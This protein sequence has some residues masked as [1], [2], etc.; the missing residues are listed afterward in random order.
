VNTKIFSTNPPE[1]N[2]VLGT[3][4]K[5]K[6]LIQSGERPIKFEVLPL[7]SDLFPQESL[8]AVPLERAFALPAN[9]YTHPTVFQHERDWIFRTHWLQVA[10]DQWL[11]EPGSFYPVE[12]AGLPVVLV[13]QQ[14]GQVRAFHNVCQHRAG[15][16]AEQ[17]GRGK[18]LRCHYHGWTYGLD[19]RLLA[20]PEMET[21][22]HFCKETIQ[23]A[24]VPVCE[25]QG[26]IF[27]HLGQPSDDLNRTLRAI[28]QRIAPI[29]FA[30]WRFH[31][32]VT[33]DVA[34]NWKVYVENYLEGYHLPTVH[35][36]LT[37]LL[38]ADQYTTECHDG[39]SLQTSPLSAAPPGSEEVAASP[40]GRA[41]GEAFYVFLYPNLML[42]LL[43]NRLQLNRVIPIAPEQTQV[44]FEYYYAPDQPAETLFEAD[45]PISDLIQQED[46]QICQQ[47][48]R[49]LNSPGYR[50]GPLCPAQEAGAH[51]FHQWL[52]AVY[53]QGVYDRKEAGPPSAG[54]CDALPNR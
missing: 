31:Q 54:C 46:I 3:G 42:N 21:A 44:V 47:V 27:I 37:R 19:G 41:P 15:P 28:D 45:H 50:P 33:Y 40:Y 20:A 51:H 10:H 5:L 30:N 13:R 12:I 18:S 35:P 39:F 8:S 2:L 16:L 4:R 43:P 24:P 14:D 25:W 9:W 48:Q 22:P 17:P 26:F 6:N 49:G 52:R 1:W 36:Q 29:Q 34:C 32:R 7:L 53:R 11:S 23:L 38:Q